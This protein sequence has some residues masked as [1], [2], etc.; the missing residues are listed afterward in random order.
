MIL[1]ASCLYRNNLKHRNSEA[2][3]TRSKIDSS[4]YFGVNSLNLHNDED[5]GLSIQRA[6]L[7]L[8]NRALVL[9][10]ACFKIIVLGISG[11]P[12]GLGHLPTYGPL[13][14]LEE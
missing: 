4:G 5:T 13:A 1:E 8:R 14:H 7:L 12:Q 10:V 9:R 6:R 11:V 2:K 3:P